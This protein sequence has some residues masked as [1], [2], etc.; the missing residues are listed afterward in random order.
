MQ[1][2]VF[3]VEAGVDCLNRLESAVVR[4]LALM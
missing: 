4:P 2:L 3:P 1:I